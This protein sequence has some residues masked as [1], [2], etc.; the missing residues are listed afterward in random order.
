VQV[1]VDALDPAVLRQLFED[2]IAPYWDRAA[3]AA[4]L[5]REECHRVELARLI[6]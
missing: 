1:E 5:E 4:V 3:H 6:S 2:A